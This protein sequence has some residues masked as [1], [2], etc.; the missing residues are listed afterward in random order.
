M[1]SLLR[2]LSIGTKVRDG[3]LPDRVMGTAEDLVITKSRSEVTEKDK[4]ELKE[5]VYGQQIYLFLFN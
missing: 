4:T 3:I 5:S 2:K 1:L